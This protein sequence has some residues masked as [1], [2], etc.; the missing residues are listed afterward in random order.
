MICVHFEI[1]S[2]LSRF[3]S[4]LR[5]LPEEAIPAIA[6][7]NN[8]RPVPH[9]T[10]PVFHRSSWTSATS[11]TTWQT[12]MPPTPPLPTPRHKAQWTDCIAAQEST[13]PSTAFNKVMITGLWTRT[14]I[15][16][17][18]VCKSHC[19]ATIVKAP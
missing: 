3:F 4:S 11:S 16:I 15:Y 19:P 8:G 12:P 1:F 18:C 10:T 7:P 5:C 17:V 13:I 9:R 14:Y 6:Y 2:W